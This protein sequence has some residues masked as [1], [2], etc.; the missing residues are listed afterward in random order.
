MLALGA[1]KLSQI[2]PGLVAEFDA[3]NILVVGAGMARSELLPLTIVEIFRSLC[4]ALHNSAVELEFLSD[5]RSCLAMYRLAGM[6]AKGCSSKIEGFAS[7]NEA[8]MD[9]ISRS[10]RDAQSTVNVSGH[11]GGGGMV[12]LL[13]SHTCRAEDDVIS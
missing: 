2:S 11:I 10:Y 12:S 6:V 3:R 5:A 13:K 8:L 9:S 1:D 7:G 4:I